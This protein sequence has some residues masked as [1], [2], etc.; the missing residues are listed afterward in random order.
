M[1]ALERDLKRILTDEGDV[2]DAELF[3]AERLDPGQAPGGTGLTATFSAR[4]RPSQLLG[5]VL[6]VLAVLPRDLHRLPRAIDIDVDWKRI[7]V[8]QSLSA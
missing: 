7:G 2:L 8:L 5:C 4:T 3:G 1:T 6:R